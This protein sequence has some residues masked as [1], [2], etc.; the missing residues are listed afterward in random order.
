MQTKIT[1]DDV[2]KGLGILA[3]F[4]VGAFVLASLTGCAVDNQFSRGAAL[5]A[6]GGPVAIHAYEVTAENPD[7][8][9]HPDQY[10]IPSILTHGGIL[11]G[12]GI[13]FPPAALGYLGGITLYGG[14]RAC[15]SKKQHPHWSW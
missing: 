10:V 9:D 3:T 2:W 7:H 13:A 8:P 6:L 1:K 14:A 15:I 12:L 11:L 4:V 5:G